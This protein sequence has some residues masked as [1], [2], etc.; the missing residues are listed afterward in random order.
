M[1][2]V[3]RTDGSSETYFKV[4]YTKREMSKRL[5]AL[6]T[7]CPYRLELVKTMQGTHAKEMELHKQL[8]TSRIHGEWYKD[9][10][11]VRETLGLYDWAGYPSQPFVASEK[12]AQVLD[13]FTRQIG[14][15]YWLFGD[16]LKLHSIAEVDLRT[17]PFSQRNFSIG[18]YDFEMM[19]EFGLFHGKPFRG[20]FLCIGSR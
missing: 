11:N 9:D 6:Q 14:A 8:Y 20:K 4:G 17:I 13:F 18:L 12:Q 15:H 1:I 7:G 19:S 10:F 3:L 16:F 2:Y 5:K